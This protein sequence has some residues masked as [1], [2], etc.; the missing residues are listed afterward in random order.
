M[1]GCVVLLF[2]PLKARLDEV[3]FHAK[4]TDRSAEHWARSERIR[5][6]NAANAAKR[7][8]EQDVINRL[9]P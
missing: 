5:R 1:W 4:L 7:E 6:E 8:L 2:L 3:A 9:S